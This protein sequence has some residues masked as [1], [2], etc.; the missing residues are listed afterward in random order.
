MH[1]LVIQLA[2]VTPHTPA[3]PPVNGAVCA[4]FT[5]LAKA[6]VFA[7]FPGR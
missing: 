2:D 5:M 7:L 3:S 6:N 1:L 4:V